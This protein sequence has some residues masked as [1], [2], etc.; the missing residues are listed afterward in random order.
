[1]LKSTVLYDSPIGRIYLAESD[2]VITDLRFSPVHGAVI[3][4]TPLMAQAISQL[5]EYF[6]GTRRVF[7]LPLAPSGTEFQEKAWRALLAIPYGETRSYKEQAVAVG[8][9]RAFRAVGMANNKNPISIIIPCHR[10]IGADKSL[11]GYGGGLG[12]KRFLLEHE[13]KYN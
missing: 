9:D 13:T 7:D 12:I 10:V 4:E 3:Q 2:G 6:A 8:N 1:M 5:H 11:T